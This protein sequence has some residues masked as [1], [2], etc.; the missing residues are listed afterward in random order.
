M[1]GSKQINPRFLTPPDIG[2]LRPDF[3]QLLAG[4]L[5]GG[6]GG[7]VNPLGNAAMQQFQGL[8]TGQGPSGPGTSAYQSILEATQTGLPANTGPI[9]DQAYRNFSQY[10]APAIKE[11]LG[12]QYGI[13]FGTPVSE[14]LS[15]AGA[16]VT[17]NLNAEFAR[18]L[19][20]FVP[21]RAGGGAQP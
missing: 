8:L 6:A 4:L 12:A 19:P 9:A 5:S 13:R 7:N 3:A 17:S 21:P 18:R 16:D 14:S 1:G 2:T 11:Q 20:P 15:R 10:G